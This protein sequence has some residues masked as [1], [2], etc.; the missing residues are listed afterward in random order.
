MNLKQAVNKALSQLQLYNTASSEEYPR[1]RLTKHL[2]INNS[3]ENPGTH[4]GVTTH[5]HFQTFC[6]KS[7]ISMFFESKY[8]C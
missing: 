1:E 6:E 2:Q 3:F 5:R 7:E 4:I 8:Y